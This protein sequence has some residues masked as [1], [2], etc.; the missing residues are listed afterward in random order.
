MHRGSNVPKFGALE[1][2]GALLVVRVMR[3]GN[4]TIFAAPGTPG[5]W[6]KKTLQRLA[7]ESYDD[8]EQT[9]DPTE[10]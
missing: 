9:F 4:V 2:Q 5:A 1:M 10:N 6:V 8:V 7:D 3:D